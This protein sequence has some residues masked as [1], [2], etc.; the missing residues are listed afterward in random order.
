LRDLAAVGPVVALP[1]RQPHHLSIT[2]TQS[3]SVFHPFVTLTWRRVL[4]Q[5]IISV[6]IQR[7]KIGSTEVC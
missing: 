6:S 3:S 7:H 2:V 5:L 4:G 1:H